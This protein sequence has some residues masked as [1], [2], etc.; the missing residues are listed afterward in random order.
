MIIAMDGVNYMENNTLA[1]VAFYIANTR[2]NPKLRL[3]DKIVS[4]ID[5]SP[6]S[7]V[8]LAIPLERESSTFMCY[9]SSIR[10]GGVRKKQIELTSEHW[11]LVPVKID[12]SRAMAVFNYYE[13]CGYD[14]LGL[15]S[16]KWKWFPNIPNHFF[17]SEIVANMLGKIDCSN[18]GVKRLYEDL[19]S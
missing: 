15:G 14:L 17:C 18:Y 5:G 6:Y 4:Y 10:D 8:E 12:L 19:T 13:G 11:I 2:V 1:Y 3:W 16:T 7:H 9:S